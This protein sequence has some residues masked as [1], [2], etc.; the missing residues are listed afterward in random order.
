LGV[1]ND[2]ICG[3]VEI[4]FIKCQNLVYDYN[5][6]NQSGNTAVRNQQEG[7]CSVNFVTLYP[8]SELVKMT[9]SK[10]LKTFVGIFFFFTIF[11]LASSF[12][13]SYLEFMYMYSFADTLI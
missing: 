8:A 7:D 12:A 2:H 10:R 3:F 13:V 1:F 6:C 11:V 5:V 4:F 9:Q